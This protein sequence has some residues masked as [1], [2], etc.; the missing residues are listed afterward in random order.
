MINDVDTE[1]DNAQKSIPFISQMYDFEFH[2]DKLVFYRAYNVGKG[3]IFCFNCMYD[4]YVTQHMD[5]ALTNNG[6]LQVRTLKGQ[7]RLCQNLRY[8][9]T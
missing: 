5:K 6:L 1:E 8:S 3:N 9:F 7:A 2:E 4:I